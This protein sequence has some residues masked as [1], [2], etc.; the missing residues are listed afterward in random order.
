MAEAKVKTSE[1]ARALGVSYQ[2]VRKVLQGG[3]FG[4][5]NN[6]A[7]ARRLGV[8]SDWLATG[9]GP[10]QPGRPHVVAEAPAEQYAEV[11]RDLEDIPPNLRHRLIDQI[12]QEAEKAREAAA[13]HSNRDPQL[14]P[15]ERMTPADDARLPGILNRDAAQ[16]KRST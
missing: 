6:A 8:N 13:Y 7:A 4:T 3:Q 10:R 16:R 12:Q 15:H 14:A 9:K 2:A 11:L 1:L 5:E